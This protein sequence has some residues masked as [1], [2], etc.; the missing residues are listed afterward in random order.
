M[1]QFENAEYQNILEKSL[2]RT[3]RYTKDSKKKLSDLQECLND[4]KVK[5]VE[6]IL[7]LR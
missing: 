2:K 7:A 5:E 4:L 1:F 6:L 3:S